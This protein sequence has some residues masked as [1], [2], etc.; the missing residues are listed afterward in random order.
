MA[1]RKSR[2]RKSPSAGLGPVEWRLKGQAAASS[3]TI[4]PNSAQIIFAERADIKAI[5]I[6]AFHSLR[7][8]QVVQIAQRNLKRRLRKRTA[9]RHVDVVAEQAHRGKQMAF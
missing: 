3:F 2:S 9:K 1:A 6:N 7:V 5:L 4:F 8:R